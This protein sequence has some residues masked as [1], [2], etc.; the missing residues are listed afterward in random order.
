M[1]VYI[2]DK[3]MKKVIVQGHWF[4]NITDQEYEAFGNAWN[5]GNHVF[6][7]FKRGN[8]NRGFDSI[9]FYQCERY[10]Q[11]IIIVQNRYSK[12]TYNRNTKSTSYNDCIK[13]KKDSQKNIKKCHL[14]KELNRHAYDRI[15]GTFNKN[16]ENIQV[17][18]L[19]ITTRPF[20][21]NNNSREEL[22]TD[23]NIVICDDMSNLFGQSIAHSLLLND[24][25]VLLMFY[26]IKCYHCVLYFCY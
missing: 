9:I 16:N 19:Y 23:H 11:M 24:D 10:E 26:Y 1:Y 6:I 12:P 22:L 21:G 14:M 7:S 5:D 18:F 15:L 3:E 20:N 25:E 2:C 8:N 4:H 13:F 17:Y